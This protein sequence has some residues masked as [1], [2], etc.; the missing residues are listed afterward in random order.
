MPGKAIVAATEETLTIA[1]PL[2]AGPSGRIARRPCLM[3]S[4]VPS[5]LT[6][7]IF[8]RSSASMSTISP[9]I[10]IPALLTRMSSPPSCSIVAATAASQL[11]S[12]VT[13]RR[14][15]ERA[16]RL[17]RLPGEIVLHVADHHLRAGRGERLRHPRAEPLRAAG[18]ER[19]AALEHA[20]SHLVSS[21]SRW[22]AP[23]PTTPS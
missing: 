10:S 15:R 21:L 16:D 20:F 12:S 13:S 6:S 22:T 9:E 17:R 18:H 4:A 8:L 1:P 23:D 14:R 2:P 11:A 7:S 19:L 5:T 3:P